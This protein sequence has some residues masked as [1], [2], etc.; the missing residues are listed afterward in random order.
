MSNKKPM[1]PGFPVNSIGTLTVS[2]ADA[3]TVPAEIIGFPVLS[4]PPLSDG[5]K[6]ETRYTVSKASSATAATAAP[7]I[8]AIFFLLIKAP[9]DTAEIYIIY[10]SINAAVLSRIN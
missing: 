9:L 5:L 10:N 4:F 8:M 3:V 6:T 7:E 1:A 2:P